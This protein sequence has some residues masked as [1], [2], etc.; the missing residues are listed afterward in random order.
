MELKTAKKKRIFLSPPHMGGEEMSFIKEAFESNY[1]AP[2]GPQVDV[3]EKEFAEYV[4]AKGAL[5]LSSGTA[6]IHLA[7]RFVHVAQGDTVFCS[8]LTFIGSA[9]PILY[10]GAIPVFID[11]EPKSWNMSPAAL[12]RAFRDAEKSGRLP[13]AVIA[14]NLY[15]QSADMTPLLAVCDHYGVPVIEDAAESL[16]ATYYQRSEVGGKKSDVRSRRSEV[17]KRQR[18]EVGSRGR[19]RGRRSEVGGR[20]K[21][22]VRSRRSEVRSGHKVIYCVASLS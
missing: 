2:L 7:L 9:N 13:K 8:S 12:E 10:Q 15:G 11:A 14:V 6:A 1:I 22:E 19:D 18:S 21:T 20:E 4:G 5:A 17:G 16:G 3:F